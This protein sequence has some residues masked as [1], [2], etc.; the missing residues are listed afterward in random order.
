MQLGIHCDLANNTS[1]FCW[2]HVVLSEDRN[3]LFVTEQE[4][5]MGVW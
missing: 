2:L 3:S 4:A 1:W 5:M